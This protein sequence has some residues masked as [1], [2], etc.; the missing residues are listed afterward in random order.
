MRESQREK[1][2]VSRIAASAV[3]SEIYANV[4]N[5]IAAQFG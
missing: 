4:I 3:F 2:K 1:E 5:A